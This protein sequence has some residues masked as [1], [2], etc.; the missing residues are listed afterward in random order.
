MEVMLRFH[1]T[2]CRKEFIVIDEQIESDSLTCPYCD[3]GIDVPQDDD[4]DEDED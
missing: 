4:E 3:Q 1:C 2:Y